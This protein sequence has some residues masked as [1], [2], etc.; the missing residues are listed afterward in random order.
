MTKMVLGMLCALMYVWAAWGD[1]QPV[2]NFNA[3]KV[4]GKWYMVAFAT[5]AY[6]FRNNV[7]GLKRGQGMWVPNENGDIHMAFTNLKNN[8]VCW[9]LS[10]TATKTD[11]PGIFTFISP[12][13]GNEN[14]MSFVD[15]KY[16]EYALIHTNK[17]MRGFEEILN[18]LFSRSPIITEELKQKF[19][20]F[21]QATGINDTNISILADNP[22]CPEKSP[23]D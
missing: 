13:W 3:T 2:S 4:A 23:P 1:I 22:E 6:W 19:I 18:N 16:D 14:S 21:S 12:T 9:K 10:Y 15:V 8:N 17:I 20:S 7:G 11:M 5:N